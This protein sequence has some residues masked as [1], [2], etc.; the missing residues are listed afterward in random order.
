MWEAI[1][2]LVNRLGCEVTMLPAEGRSK[3]VI[4]VKRKFSDR[5][6]GAEKIIP[7]EDIFKERTPGASLTSAVDLLVR[8]F[9]EAQHGTEQT[10]RG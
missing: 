6:F 2:E 9:H 4:R 3:M 7:R 5:E 1:N 10:K 8:Q